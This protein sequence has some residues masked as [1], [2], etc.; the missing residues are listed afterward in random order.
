MPDTTKFLLQPFFSN[1]DKRVFY[2]KNM[3]PVLKGALLSR[4]SRSTLPLRE[5][6]VKDYLQTDEIDLSELSEHMEVMKKV[7]ALLNTG[8]AQ[9][10][11]SKWLAMYGDD[12]IAELGEAHVG[13]ENVS[14]I[15]AKSLEDRRI[16]LSPLEK[17][18]R[19]IRFDQKDDE[20]HYLYYRDPEI[21]DSGFNDVYISTMDILFDTYSRLLDPMMAYFEETF[22]KP[23]DVSV[24]AYR[25]SIR[26]KGCDVL[27]GLL[28]MATLTNLGIMGNGRA[29]EYAITRLLADP[30]PESRALGEELLDELYQ[31]IPN[32]LERIRTK[33]GE[34]YND[35]LEETA[36]SVYQGVKAIALANEYAS[37]PSIT[38]LWH[39]TDAVTKTIA[40]MLFPESEATFG[41]C[42]QAARNMTPDEQDAMLERYVEHRQGRWHK[43]GVAFEEVYYSFE[44]VCDLGAY[45]DLQRHRIVSRY[46]QQFTTRHGY[47][48]PAEVIDAGF[49][50]E[51][52]TAMDAAADAYEQ[53]VDTLPAQAQYFACHGHLG[54]WRIKM[55]LREA[56]HFC[57]LRSSSQGHPNYRVVAQEMYRIIQ[58]VHPQLGNLMHYVDMEDPGLERLSAE[59]RKEDKLKMAGGR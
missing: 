32:F 9:K 11:Y 14:I 16:G 12:S 34:M 52:R 15:A 50:K 47:V 43:V 25:T 40:S 20:G 38:L 30:M 53:M 31:L 35:Y 19:Y 1:I 48:V 54:R 23:E 37:K 21:L 28:P 49:E 8:K 18:T 36:A 56:F 29:W 39:D 46:R 10:F 7:D 45:K 57:E 33:K 26:A 59:I 22:P 51:Y 13:I 2:L 55:N 42:L 5:L 6:F 41:E 17:S 4:Y 3:P 27:R 44:I 58:E 24:S